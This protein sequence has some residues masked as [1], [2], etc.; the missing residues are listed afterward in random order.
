MPAAPASSCLRLMFGILRV[1]APARMT[2][3]VTVD[4]MRTDQRRWGLAAIGAVAALVVG[5]VAGCSSPDTGTAVTVTQTVTAP[6]SGAFGSVGASGSGG[7]ASTSSGGGSITVVNPNPATTPADGGAGVT[8]DAPSG[9]S[10]TPGAPGD[11]A[12]QT[13]ATTAPS[14]TAMTTPTGP[15]AK[16]AARAL[17][18]S[19]THILSATNIA[20]ALGK[21]LSP[22]NL[23]VVDVANPDNQMTARTKCYYGTTDIAAARPVVVALASYMDADAAEK[24]LR[25][26]VD[27]ER[28]A[29]AQGSALDAGGHPASILLRDGG[30]AVARV[31]AVT[32]SVAI[33][34]GVI[35][36][37]A[38]RGAL[39]V[40]MRTV[41][42]HIR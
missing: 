31:G 24:Q 8:V 2:S 6:A 28:A 42:S 23:R 39:I 41:V 27:A 35:A 13:P 5:L 32:V 36:D 11:T 29:G 15:E 40:A 18:T 10:Q 17:A 1:G 20:T 21:A 37:S 34:K 16:A 30:L 19:C 9:A 22:D 33:A 38:L 26:T 14:T 3:F 7:A 12:G 4:C 25:V